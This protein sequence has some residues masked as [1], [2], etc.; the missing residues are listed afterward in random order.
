M[1]FSQIFCI[2]QEQLKIFR[3]SIKSLFCPSR[4]GQLQGAFSRNQSTHVHVQARVLTVGDVPDLIIGVREGAR[5]EGMNGGQGVFRLGKFDFCTEKF[6]T[7]NSASFNWI[8]FSSLITIFMPNIVLKLISTGV[9][10][11]PS[12]RQTGASA[13]QPAEPATAAAIQTC[14]VITIRFLCLDYL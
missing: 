4:E 6:F 14:L 2:A 5:L 1:I 10:A 8:S 13:R 9:P 3:S 7:V 11:L 12:A